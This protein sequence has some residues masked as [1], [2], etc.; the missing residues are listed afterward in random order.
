MYY[1]D[2]YNPTIENDFDQQNGNIQMDF[3]DATDNMTVNSQI[4][5][6]R[7]LIQEAKLQDKGY[8]RINRG[9]GFVEIYGGSDCI[10]AP[11]RN[12]ITSVRFPQYRVGSKDENLF[13]KVVIATGEKG[14]RGNRAFY[15]DD[16]EQYERHMQNTVSEKIKSAWSERNIKER[17]SRKEFQ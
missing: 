9:K 8:S 10:G 1:D 7:K 15:F 16:P 4:V 11:I 2:P 17:L 13:F 14:L 5:K 12:A 3:D 6:N